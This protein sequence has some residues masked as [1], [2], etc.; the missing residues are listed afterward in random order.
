MY[1]KREDAIDIIDRAFDEYEENSLPRLLSPY[2]MIRYRLDKLPS[3]DVVERK[4]MKLIKVNPNNTAYYSD[5]F[6]KGFECGAK[7]QF[8]ADMRADG[9]E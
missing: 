1:I 9:K 3:A 2:S 4:M 6:I 8:E 5:E 7:R